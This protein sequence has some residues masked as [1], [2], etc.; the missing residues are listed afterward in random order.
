MEENSIK[1]L[2]DYFENIDP[3]NKEEKQLVIESFQPRLYRKPQFVLQKGQQVAGV[4]GGIGKAYDGSYAE[5]TVSPQEILVSFK[6]SLNWAIL[7]AIPEMF[8][9]VS[10][11]LN[12]A[13]KIAEGETITGKSW[14]LLHRHDDN[15]ICQSTR[16][17][18]YCHHKKRRKN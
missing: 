13:L 6:S 4:M 11:S 2:I 12:L 14:H 8:H 17:D 5:F 9:T 3:L 10:G 18:R 7:G 16:I 1:P 15:P